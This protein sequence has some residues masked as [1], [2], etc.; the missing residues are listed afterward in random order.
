VAVNLH[1]T[2]VEALTAAMYEIVGVQ[3]D[4]APSEARLDEIERRQSMWEVEMEALVAAAAGKYEAANNAEA[5][6]RTMK[7]HYA[8]LVDPF[9]EESEEVTEAVPPG[10]APGGETE[11]VQPVRVDVATNHKANA[12]IRKWAR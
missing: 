12:L 11:G 7:R 1:R 4:G 6:T 2:A 5:R 9:N 3:R 10:D 8:K